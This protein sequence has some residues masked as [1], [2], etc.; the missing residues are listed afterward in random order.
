MAQGGYKYYHSR[1]KVH[2]PSRSLAL[3]VHRLQLQM[4]TIPG[5]GSCGGGKQSM[6]R[7]KKEEDA[8]GVMAQDLVG[9]F[10]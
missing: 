2:M 6:S 10:C 1:V 5:S 7:R 4:P 8:N 9:V 3:G